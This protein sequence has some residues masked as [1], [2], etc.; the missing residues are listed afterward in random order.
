MHDVAPLEYP[1]MFHGI[2]GRV[3]GSYVPLVEDARRALHQSTVPGEMR[4]FFDYVVRDNPQPSFLLLPLLFLASADTTGGITMEH[5][6]YLPVLM[7]AMEIV[8]IA[9]DTVDRT[10]VRSGRPTFPA[11][12]GEGSSTPFAGALLAMVAERARRID[13]RIF[14]ITMRFFVDLFANELWER[15]NL[16]PPPE[17]FERWLDHRYRQSAAGAAFALNT[18]LIL[19]DRAP[20]PEEATERFGYVF[21]DVDDLVNLLEHRDAAGENDD[22]VMGMVTMPLLHALRCRPALVADLQAL[23]EASRALGRASLADQPRERALLDARGAEQYAPIR[24]AII[25][26]GVPAVVERVL[27]NASACVAASPP[28]LRGIMHEMTSTFADRLRRCG[29]PE[30]I[31]APCTWHTSVDVVREGGPC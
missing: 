17:T 5:R 25:T 28:P 7:L 6:R 26:L 18:A 13:A 24:D 11:R 20:L 22:I 3:R 16:Y 21:Q 23:W 8:A 14:D 29:R 31:A 1:R 27:A 19:N 2:F 9:D 30:L 4:P 10:P 12:F 15:Q